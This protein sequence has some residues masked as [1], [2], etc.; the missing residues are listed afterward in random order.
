MIERFEAFLCHNTL[1][2]FDDDD[3]FNDP[4]VSFISIFWESRVHRKIKTRQT[5]IMVYNSLRI[6]GY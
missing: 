6:W 1:T 5:F 3:A 4:F 2:Y